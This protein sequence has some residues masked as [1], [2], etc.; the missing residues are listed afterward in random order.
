MGHV[1]CDRRR[2][3]AIP[4]NAAGLVPRLDRFPS[5]ENG[6]RLSAGWVWH[7]FSMVAVFDLEAAIMRSDALD[8]PVEI[9]EIT[10][11]VAAAEFLRNDHMLVVTSD[12]SLDDNANEAVIGANS[13]A[14]ID[15]ET[16]QVISRS[17]TAE[18]GD[19]V[20]REP[21]DFFHSR[22]VSG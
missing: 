2:R 14:V 21:N 4:D 8:R 19:G 3:H 11:E 16:R 20:I 9:P 12:E 5:L 18:P 10:G 6:T 1:D 17:P 22:L 13:I 7:P 15:L